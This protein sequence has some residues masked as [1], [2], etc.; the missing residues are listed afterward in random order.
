VTT[1]LQLRDADPKW[2]RSQ[3]SVVM[4]RLVLELQ[5]HPCLQLEDGT[6][7]RK[8]IMASRSFSRP[9]RYQEIQEA[10]ATYISRAAERM[11]RQDLVAPALQVFITTNRFR[12]NDEQYYGQHTVHLPVATSDTSRLIRAA[13]HGLECVWKPGHRYKKAGVVCWD[14]HPAGNVQSGLFHA[15]DTPVRRELMASLDTLNQRFG[16]GTQAFSAGGIQKAW[17]LRSDQ[18]SPAYTTRWSEL[19]NVL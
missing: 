3:F 16:R 2:I 6:P 17:K 15:P 19:L 1:P 4:E 11:R 5:G 14:L 13:L 10:V 9:V 12:V 7:D 8:T 18:R